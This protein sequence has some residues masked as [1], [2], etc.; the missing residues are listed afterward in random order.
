MQTDLGTLHLL[1]YWAVFSMSWATNQSL[2]K[3]HSERGG[4]MAVPSGHRRLTGVD[5]I[6]MSISSCASGD[7]IYTHTRA[8]TLWVHVSPPP[9]TGDKNTLMGFLWG[10]KE[11]EEGVEKGGIGIE[12][13]PACCCTVIYPYYW[14][15]NSWL[16]KKVDNWDKIPG[17]AEVG[18]FLDQKRIERKLN[19]KCYIYPIPKTPKSLFTFSENFPCHCSC[20]GLATPPKR[21]YFI[22]Q[23]IR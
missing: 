10:D 12:E 14:F 9:V 21:S 2:Y 4:C 6:T 7:R 13:L 18:Y 8:H 1:V 20:C 19:V 11:T 3:I 5:T 17:E 15:S 16:K 22:S 23:F